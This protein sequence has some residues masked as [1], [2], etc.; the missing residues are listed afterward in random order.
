MWTAG[1]AINLNAR[2]GEAARY[3]HG[4]DALE[5]AVGVPQQHRLADAGRG[6][7]C[8]DLVARPGKA[9]HSEFHDAAGS[10]IDST[11]S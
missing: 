7:Q 9:D 2:I 11:I 10:P 5:V 1:N 8:V 3:D 4:V 6:L